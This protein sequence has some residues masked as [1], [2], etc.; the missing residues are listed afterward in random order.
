M[1][2]ASVILD[3]KYKYH[4]LRIEDLVDQSTDD[5]ISTIENYINVLSSSQHDTYTS[6]FEIV[7]TNMGK[8]KF[9]IF[10]L[11]AN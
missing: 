4:W 8:W 5:L 9:L 1:H 6:P 7:A 2:S 3:V 10:F 11:T